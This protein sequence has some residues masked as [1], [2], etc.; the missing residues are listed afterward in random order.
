MKDNWLRLPCKTAHRVMTEI[1]IT[2]HFVLHFSFHISFNHSSHNF[3][4][5][6]FFRLHSTFEFLSF[7]QIFSPSRLRWSA[8]CLHLLHTKGLVVNRKSGRQQDPK[9]PFYEKRGK[10]GIWAFEPWHREIY[11]WWINPPDHNALQLL[12]TL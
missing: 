2:F 1:K 3:Y 10:K 4:S 11:S 9:R 7:R 8:L 12:L 5:L 6:F